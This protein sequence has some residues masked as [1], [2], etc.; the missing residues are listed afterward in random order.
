VIL[1][2][3]PEVKRQFRRPKHK[4]E[5][6]IEMNVKEIGHEDVDRTV[7]QDRVQRRGYVNTV[8]NLRVTK[9]GGNFFTS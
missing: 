8:M 3:K 5:D 1:V 2:E 4:W 6:N 9:S 7:A